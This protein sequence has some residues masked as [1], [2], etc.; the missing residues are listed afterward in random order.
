MELIS[1]PI[2]D[3]KYASTDKDMKEVISFC[4]DT[5]LLGTDTETMVDLKKLDATALDAHSAEISLVQVNSINN[6]VPY[7]IDFISISPDAKAEFNQEVLMNFSIRKVLHNAR[8]DLKQF[9][10]EF[11]TWPTNVWCTMVLM[12]SLGRLTICP[13]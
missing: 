12:K 11:G 1:T 5:D 7:L 10:S 3:I 9:Y 13:V 6:A 8:F 2:I 4:K